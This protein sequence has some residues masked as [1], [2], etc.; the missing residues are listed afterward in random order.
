M[1]SKG[2]RALILSIVNPVSSSAQ[3]E[4]G[5]CMRRTVAVNQHSWQPLCSEDALKVDAFSE[6]EL[7]CATGTTEE[8]DKR[9][10]M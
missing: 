9:L 10:R 3:Q 7:R 5:M 1:I 6:R 2:I 4:M 8:A